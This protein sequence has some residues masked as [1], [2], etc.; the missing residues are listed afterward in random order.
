M[1]MVKQLNS[2]F[3]EQSSFTP[4]K[5][6]LTYFDIAGLAQCIR[7]VL[8]LNNFDFE[9]ERLNK[10]DFMKHKMS[11]PFGQLPTLVVDTGDEVVTIA[12][13]KAILRYTGRL[14]RTY[15]SRQPL[16]AAMIDQWCELHTEFNTPLMLSMF[17]ERFGLTGTFDV[18]SHRRWIR[19]THLPRF[20]KYLEVEL[21]N[22]SYLGGMD[23]INIADFCWQPTLEWLK[24]G[25]FEGVG[26]QDFEDYNNLQTYMRSLLSEINSLGNSLGYIEKKEE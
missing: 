23:A 4:P 18:E 2:F 19:E 22:S 16:H 25:V 21:D 9:D 11:L 5:L 3:R 26:E 8:S 6:K 13:S 20:F 12:Q 10:V 1:I 14:T 17:P 7:N 24:S 15:P